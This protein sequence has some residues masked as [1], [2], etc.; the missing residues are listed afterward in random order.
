MSKEEPPLPSARLG[1]RGRR[2]SIRPSPTAP[3][4]ATEW[5]AA[6]SLQFDRELAVLRST[7]E[8]DMW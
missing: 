4:V 8:A 7:S 5:R 3:Y 1:V 6:T 2:F